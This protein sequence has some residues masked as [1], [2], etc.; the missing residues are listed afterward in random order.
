MKLQSKYKYIQPNRNVC[1]LLHF[2][3]SC[4][5]L[6]L[7]T[8][9]DKWAVVHRETWSWGINRWNP[10]LVLISSFFSEYFPLA[11]HFCCSH[12]LQFQNKNDAYWDTFWFYIQTS[13][14]VGFTANSH[15]AS[16]LVNPCEFNHT[17]LF[18]GT[19]ASLWKWEDLLVLDP[20]FT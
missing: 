18:S 6:F 12:R 7:T 13:G 11:G 3:F 20:N 8:L 5:A 15:W 16:K 4:A 10:A 14:H 19:E 1:M 17:S 9:L 2:S